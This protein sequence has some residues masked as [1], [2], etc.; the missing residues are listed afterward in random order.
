VA[1]I[2]QNTRQYSFWLCSD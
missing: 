1:N 2:L